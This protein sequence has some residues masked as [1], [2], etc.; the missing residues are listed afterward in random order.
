MPPLQVVEGQGQTLGCLF[1]VG[2]SR[3]VRAVSLPHTVTALAALNACPA[4]SI[5]GA[6]HGCV[7]IGTAGAEV[8]LLNLRLQDAGLLTGAGWV[9]GSPARP[10]EVFRAD[11]VLHLR[12]PHA[13][14]VY[15]LAGECP[16]CGCCAGGRAR[17]VM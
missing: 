4:D 13:H 1:H 14:P 11:E 5:L 10:V 2:A 6:F 3:I 12:N 15:L 17:W 16:A 8:V 7:A 9:P